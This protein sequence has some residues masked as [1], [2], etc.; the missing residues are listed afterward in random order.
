MPKT[1]A[2]ACLAVFRLRILGVSA[3]K[4]SI[5]WRVA[6][7]LC[8]KSCDPLAISISVVLSLTRMLPGLFLVTETV[9]LERLRYSPER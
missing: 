8:S 5:N 9:R 4:R 3:I 2:A 7:S 6:S 1:F